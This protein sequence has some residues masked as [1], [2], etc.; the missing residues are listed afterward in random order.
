[1]RDAPVCPRSAPPSLSFC[2]P[3]QWT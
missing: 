1:V 3:R 2:R